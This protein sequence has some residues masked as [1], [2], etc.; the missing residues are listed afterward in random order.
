[1]P[2]N[3]QGSNIAYPP[4][5]YYHDGQST[6]LMDQSPSSLP[7]HKTWSLYYDH[8]LIW[9]IDKDATTHSVGDARDRS[10][11]VEPSVESDS[12]EDGSDAESELNR[13]R[14]FPDDWA[15]MS[16]KHRADDY[17][18]YAGRR[19]EKRRI[20]VSRRNQIWE[21]QILTDCYTA[22]EPASDSRFGGLVGELP[23]LI[24]LMALAV[25]EA[26][27]PTMLPQVLGNPWTG[28][29]HQD[30]LR[31]EGCQYISLM[32]RTSWD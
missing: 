2:P 15:A 9:T 21:Q 22:Q 18:S 26:Q 20:R 13:D 7:H 30:F 6:I 5:H 28:Y 29:Q 19:L 27:V 3:G 31:G 16:F 8:A 1:M 17:A 10:P 25:P 4:T 23:L 11:T 14:T 12:E 24:G 32:I